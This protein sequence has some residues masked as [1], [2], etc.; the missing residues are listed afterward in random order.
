M[1]PT[2]DARRVST[3]LTVLLVQ[4]KHGLERDDY[5]RLLQDHA[6]HVRHELQAAVPED[7]RVEL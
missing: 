2:L 4:A 3:D 5:L 1:R 7:E 6:E